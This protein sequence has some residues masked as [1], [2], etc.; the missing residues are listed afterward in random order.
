MK[1]VTRLSD[2]KFALFALACALAACSSVPNTAPVREHGPAARTASKPP[3]AERTPVP[4]ARTEYVVKPGDTLYSIALENG[5][6]YRDLTRW[7]NL[8]DPT[9]ISVGQTLRLTSP[10][11]AAAAPPPGVEV[12]AARG[13]G[14]VESHPL[15]A[16]SSAQQGAGDGGVKTSPK[17]LRLPYSS[18]NL[19]MLSKEAQPPGAQ[20]SAPVGGSPAPA[21]APKAETKSETK[22]EVAPVAKAEAK[23][24]WQPADPDAKSIGFIWPAHGQLLA[25]FS[26]QSNRGV[27][28][29]GRLG[30]PVYAAAPGRV[31]YTGTGIRGYGK[32]I[33]IKHENGFNSV[34]A[35][36]KTILV[37]EGQTVTR[38]E[39][40]AELGE[41]DAS[42]PA[43]HFEIRKSGK[44]VDPLKYL[45]NGKPPS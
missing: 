26:E 39:R 27:D 30:D 10:Q 20:P 18:G 22:P 2:W 44:P 17:A 15:D 13:I 3:V 16:T 28:I 45:P 36:N 12:G 7:N 5:V 21:P 41:T 42:K 34:Y 25:G 43:L 11:E 1:R 23:P 9:K 14:P 4:G 6:D 40:I 19:A 31:M 38:G 24:A 37:K 35:H 32:L 29:G 33:V 8:D